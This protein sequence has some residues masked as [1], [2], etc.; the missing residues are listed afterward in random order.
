MS[1]TKVTS[2]TN[3]ATSPGA[4]Q[5]PLSPPGAKTDPTFEQLGFGS[6]AIYNQFQEFVRSYISYT[7]DMADM[8][9]GITSLKSTP[10]NLNTLT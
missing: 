5:A 10:K 1:S 3:N 4:P 7:I 9:L 8:L 2:P 6:Q